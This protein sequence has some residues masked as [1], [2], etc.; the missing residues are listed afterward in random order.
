MNKKPKTTRREFFKVTAGSAAVFALPHIVTSRVLAA[1][2]SGGIIRV[3][4]IGCGRIAHE[5]D[6]PGILS[7]AAARIV[8]VCD[9][10]ALRLAKTKK[11]IEDHYAKME[12]PSEV[13]A[14]ADYHALLADPKI[15]AVVISTPDHWHAQHVIEAARAG[16][17]IYVQKP[18]SLTIAEG[19][20]ASDAARAAKI[21][22]QVGSQQRS[23]TQFHDACEF[24][25]NGRVG[26]VHTVRIGLP[27]DPTAADTPAEPVPATLNYDV[28]LGSSPFAPYTEQRVHPQTSFLRPGWL[29][30]EDYTRGMITGWGSHHF[31]IAHWGMDTELTGPIAAEGKAEWPKNTIWNVHGAYHVEL[32]YANGATMIVDNTFP[33]GVRFEGDKGWIFV[34]RGSEK[35]TASDPVSPGKELKK[36]DASEPKLLAKLQAKEAIRLPVSKDHYGN[37]LEAIASGTQPIAPAEVA[38]RSCSACL[39]AWA[40]MK[41]GRKVTWDPA[42]ERFSDEAAQALVSRP[43]R[44]PYGALRAAA[45]RP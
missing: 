34:S 39:V 33:N 16:K 26:T 43:E 45:K 15:D 41:L 3:G 13:K 14:Y 25:R 35:A 40:A 18:L 17:H 31:D 28:W 7:Q 37:W 5:A 19:R 22:L 20:V 6:L 38:H 36:L 11:L 30:C 32:T 8:A 27:T 9:L 4:H 29:R 1:L 23:S 44:A 12:K 42:T 2:T 10:D 24:V 21:V